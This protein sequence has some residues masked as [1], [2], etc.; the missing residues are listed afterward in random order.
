MLIFSIVIIYSQI[1]NVHWSGGL[2][3]LMSAP[4]KLEIRHSYSDGSGDVTIEIETHDMVFI[5]FSMFSCCF[6]YKTAFGVNKGMCA[7]VLLN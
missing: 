5:Y 3:Q 7:N 1:I 4:W 6:V 2:C